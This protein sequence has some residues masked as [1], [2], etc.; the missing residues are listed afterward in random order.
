[1]MVAFIASAQ[2]E[3]LDYYQHVKTVGS[4]G[5]VETL[6]GNSGQFVKRTKIDGLPRCYDATSTGLDHCNGTL[7][8]TGMNS[9]REVYVGRSYWGNNTTYQFD[10]TNGYLNVR[11]SSGNV[12]V[13]RR[14]S[15]P[16]GRIH[17]SYLSKGANVDGWDVYAEWN[18]IQQNSVSGENYSKGSSSTGKN[19]SKGKS[20]SNSTRECGYCHGRGRVRAHVGVGGYG[21]SNKKKKCGTCGEWYNPAHDHWHACPHCKK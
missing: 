18:K 13:F 2:S 4:N 14:T 6:S 10:D 8:Y 9:G 20:S 16:A 11:D 1:M 17:S 15:P 19:Q 7:D 12:F 5:N 21:V 3:R